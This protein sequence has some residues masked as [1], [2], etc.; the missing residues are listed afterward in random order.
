MANNN[1]AAEVKGPNKQEQAL[2]N[3]ERAVDRMEKAANARSAANRAHG[4][5]AGAELDK[6]R[7]ENAVL[8]KASNAAAKRLDGAI[9]RL[10]SILES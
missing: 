9:S 10:A 8:K 3:L 6:L 1:A 7:Q 5:G 4:A 2:E